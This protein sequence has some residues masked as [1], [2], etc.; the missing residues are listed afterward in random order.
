MSRIISVLLVGTSLIYLYSAGFGTFSA[1]NQRAILLAL[2]TPV[3]FLSYRTTVNNKWF[4]K[5]LN[6]LLAVLIFA[7]NIYV[8]YVWKDRV[9]VSS[10]IPIL[11]IVVGT[12][13][14]LLLLEATRRNTGF[15]LPILVICFLVYALFGPYFPSFIAH[16]GQSWTRLTDFIFMTTEGIYGIPLGIASTYIII[17]IIFGA[18][19]QSFGGGEW[20]VDVSYAITGK[21]RGGPAKTAIIASALFGMIS[22]APA[23]NVATTGTFTIPLMKKVGYKPHVAGAIEAVASTGGIF[24]PPIMG[25]A[26]FIMAEYLEVP[27]WKVVVAAIV[28]ACLFYLA[29]LLIADAQAVK[30]GLLG[31]PADR[32]PRFAQ[33]MK[34]RGHL[35]IPIAFFCWIS[36]RNSC[37][38]E[39]SNCDRRSDRAN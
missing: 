10:D 24:T 18:F 39:G 15:F 36:I 9:L 28:P 31:L 34:E 33:T 25:A 27:Y 32:L 12:I 1:M 30:N 8:V 19:L 26:A 14:I 22:G 7:S 20:F 37:A 4:Y 11:D 29:L 13:V 2:L 21:F 38:G 6:I 23:A 35:G 17:F 3:V 5:A 16:R